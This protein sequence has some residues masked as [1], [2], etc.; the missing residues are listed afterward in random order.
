MAGDMDEKVG[1]DK[2]E[3]ENALDALA[4]WWDRHCENEGSRALA[5]GEWGFNCGEHSAITS[6]GTSW[7]VGGFQI[8]EEQRELQGA[9]SKSRGTEIVTS[10]KLKFPKTAETDVWRLFV[11]RRT[12]Q[13]AEDSIVVEHRALYQDA[14]W[15]CRTDHVYWVP[16]PSLGLGWGFSEL[17][18]R[19]WDKPEGPG[20]KVWNPH[21]PDLEAGL[22]AA[23]L[24][25]NARATGEV[26]TVEQSSNND[27]GD[28][29][30]NIQVLAE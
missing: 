20:W 10:P 24:G 25:A 11:E 26:L 30:N 18:H 3:E 14:E 9:K 4:T 21:I 13:F 17:D 12:A 29:E 7:E 5:E 27:K 19:T 28:V 23:D 15:L 1:G 22:P 6:A 8:R 16:M 2:D